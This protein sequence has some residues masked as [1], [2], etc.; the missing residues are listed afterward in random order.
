MA[1]PH[2]SSRR[3]A[4]TEQQR[5]VPLVALVVH[6]SMMSQAHAHER[7]PSFDIG[8]ADEGT[9][10]LKGRQQQGR[11][12]VCLGWRGNRIRMSAA[13]VA[14]TC[15]ALL[16]FAGLAHILQDPSVRASYV[17]ENDHVRNLLD[18]AIVAHAKCGTSFLQNTLRAHPEID[19]H[20][21][22]LHILQTGNVSGFVDALR[23]LDPTKKRGYK[24]PNDLGRWGV[25][26]AMHQYWPDTQLIVGVRH[27]V[28]HFESWYNFK[29]RKGKQLPP[30]ENMTAIPEQTRFHIHMAMLGKTNVL[31]PGEAELLDNALREQ[32][33]RLSNQVF[34][35]DVHQIFDTTNNRDV[36]FLHDLH[37]FLGLK[38][39]LYLDVEEVRAPHQ[40]LNFHYS[41]DIC[42]EKYRSMR[43][44]LLAHGHHAAKWIQTYFMN[45]T[46][47]TVSNP[48]HFSSLLD[49][50]SVDP[51]DGA[52]QR[53]R[54]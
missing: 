50:W 3:C 19:M 17:L 31:D 39:P 30:V 29:T 49:T 36:D 46:E 15:L 26:N 38:A 5:F 1:R 13:V 42:E 25:L 12:P 16:V 27:P 10:D 41:I 2:G 7:L 37:T 35:Y 45:L 32:P 18:F 4:N 6:S 24:A 8:E 22:E 11:S 54:R 23:E 33:V 34:L 20:N 47:V 52:G 14:G 44:R 40:S 43:E 53:S 21:H 51:C 28:S 48:E 9:E